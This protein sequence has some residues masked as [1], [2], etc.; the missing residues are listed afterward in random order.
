[1]KSPRIARLLLLVSAGIFFSLGLR[2]PRNNTF[3]ALGI[4]FFVLGIAAMKR[5]RARE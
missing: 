1:M 3:V 4:V 2:A 5:S